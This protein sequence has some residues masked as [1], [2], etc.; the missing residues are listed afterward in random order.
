[1]SESQMFRMRRSDGRRDTIV[2]FP[3]ASVAKPDA[4]G[5]VS[6]LSEN[7]MAMMHAGYEVIDQ[8]DLARWYQHHRAV[9]SGPRDPALLQS[10]E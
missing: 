7:V 9:N 10:K 1:M 5:A 6:V 8:G 3:N 4:D 2:Y